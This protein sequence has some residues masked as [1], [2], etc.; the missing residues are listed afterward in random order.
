MFDETSSVVL[1][2]DMSG[3]HPGRIVWKNGNAAPFFG[4]PDIQF[5]QSTINDLMPPELA[6]K[7]SSF[8][9]DFVGGAPSRKIMSTSTTFLINKDGFSE[10]RNIS[11]KP[12]LGLDS[13]RIHY[14]TYIEADKTL[15]TPFF[16]TDRQGFFVAMSQSV[17]Q[18]LGIDLLSS[19][20]PLA[21]R[22]VF[23]F[24]PALA[25]IFFLLS[26][27]FKD[28]FKP[29]D[30]R[31]QALAPALPEDFS[32]KEGV[33][34][35]TH[36]LFPALRERSDPARKR[37]SSLKQ[38]RPQNYLHFRDII[39]TITEKQKNFLSINYRVETVMCGFAETYFLFH[40]RSI[41]AG[42]Q[43]GITMAKRIRGL[44]NDPHSTKNLDQLKPEDRKLISIRRQ[45]SEFKK[46]L[47]R[48]QKASQPAAAKAAPHS[49]SSEGSEG[50]GAV[51]R[52]GFSTF[53][54]RIHRLQQV[55]KDG[56]IKGVFD[57]L[58]AVNATS[59]VL[60]ENK[61]QKRGPSFQAIADMRRTSLQRGIIFS[62]SHV[63]LPEEEV[64]TQQELKP[65]KFESQPTY[66]AKSDTARM[67]DFRL[68]PFHA[69]AGGTDSTINPEAFSGAHLSVH[70]LTSSR[71]PESSFIQMTKG[72]AEKRNF[73]VILAVIIL[74]FLGYYLL[75]V[76]LAQEHF[77]SRIVQLHQSCFNLVD[78]MT[79][80]YAGVELMILQ[81]Q[82][83]RFNVT[84][85]FPLL[86]QTLATVATQ[87]SIAARTVF[88]PDNSQAATMRDI[89][90][91]SSPNFSKVMYTSIL[92][93]DYS[94]KDQLADFVAQIN[95]PDYF[96]SVQKIPPFVQDYNVFEGILIWG[97]V[98]A[99]VL[100]CIV[101]I[102]AFAKCR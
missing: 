83:T 84:S 49:D 47:E 46:N 98:S 89:I 67:T 3:R 32:A 66:G 60:L 39:D 30:E 35:A 38:G 63:E 31:D 76:S 40:I 14:L 92:A 71:N 11:I 23:P 97:V 34:L 17:H 9:H 99:V 85:S 57:T 87:L 37:I 5:H 52:E 73:R 15:E 62:D 94:S 28:N 51:V 88:T 29:M 102:L 58:A 41:E 33:F 78:F 90:V 95:V 48:R 50:E 69:E 101:A 77:N 42:D 27:N 72:V 53:D 96:I 86:N 82:I 61:S 80:V 54:Q 68:R 64:E 20:V 8:Y 59:S 74:I 55:P 6:K 10:R 18:S 91:G 44:A 13:H 2:V 43:L 7:H 100:V 75:S 21:E 56:K 25:D 45:W 81:D 12:I 26:P 70:S 4:F 36:R 65:A 24:I 79:Q 22:S 1:E 16:M 93:A 19:D